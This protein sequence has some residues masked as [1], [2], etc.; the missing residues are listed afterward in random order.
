LLLFFRLPIPTSSAFAS[1]EAL[2]T[3]FPAWD[4]TLLPYVYQRHN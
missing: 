1:A 3:A 2:F 4:V